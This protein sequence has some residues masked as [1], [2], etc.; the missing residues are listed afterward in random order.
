M[1]AKSDIGIT[2]LHMA[3]NVEIAK[4]LVSKGA[5]VNAQGNNGST[6]LDLATSSGKIAVAEY[7]SSVGAKSGR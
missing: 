2:P 1:N 6:P 7:L 5:D 3:K 4:F